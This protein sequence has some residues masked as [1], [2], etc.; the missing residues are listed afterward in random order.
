[1]LK[2]AGYPDRVTAGG[3]VECWVDGRW[4]PA[5]IPTSIAALLEV[6]NQVRDHNEGKKE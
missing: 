5:A 1:M 3:D 4:R 2:A 6:A